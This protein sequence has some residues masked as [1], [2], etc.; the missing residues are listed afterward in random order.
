MINNEQLNSLFSA[1]E[2]STD[3]EEEKRRKKQKLVRNEFKKV[4]NMGCH[5]LKN[6]ILI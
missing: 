5:L 2:D 1:A 4:V 6:K 3:Y